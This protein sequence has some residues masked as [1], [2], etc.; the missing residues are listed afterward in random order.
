VST[1]TLTIGADA[2]ES[3]RMARVYEVDP[4]TSV[5]LEKGR[6]DSSAIPDD[7]LVVP[8]CD[9]CAASNNVFLPF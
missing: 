2:Q 7:Q 4:E 3:P 8:P 1:V 5:R 9:D 6:A